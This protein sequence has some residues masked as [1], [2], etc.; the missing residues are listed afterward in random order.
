M[1]TSD[2]LGTWESIGVIEPVTTDWTLFPD[3]VINSETL[4]LSYTSDWAKRQSPYASYGIVRFY[5]PTSEVVTSPTSRI[6]PSPDK[7]I[8]EFGI[9]PA[10]RANSVL[11]RALGVKRINRYKHEF[12]DLDPPWSIQV[13]YL[14]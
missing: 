2:S 1:A 5:Y 13:E 12:P 11:I 6:Y 4:R 14:L 9:P 8:R 3:E 7:Q 10:L